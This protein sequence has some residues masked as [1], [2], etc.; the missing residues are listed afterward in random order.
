MQIR[1][2]KRS[3]QEVMEKHGRNRKQLEAKGV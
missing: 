3:L 1:L 2:G